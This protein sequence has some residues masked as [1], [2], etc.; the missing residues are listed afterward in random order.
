MHT[1]CVYDI[2]HLKGQ[3]G[4]KTHYTKHHGHYGELFP[5]CK[6]YVE[7][8]MYEFELMFLKRLLKQ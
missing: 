5:S 2:Y 7:P 1:M 6:A 3:L 8:K 4:T